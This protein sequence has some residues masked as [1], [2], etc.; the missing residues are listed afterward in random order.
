MDDQPVKIVK[1]NDYQPKPISK[2]K[3]KTL[4]EDEIMKRFLYAKKTGSKCTLKEF[5]ESLT[6]K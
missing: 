4:T 1:D 6:K 3:E 2:K 5:T